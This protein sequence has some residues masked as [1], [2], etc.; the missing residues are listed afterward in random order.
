V[1]EE[2]VLVVGVRVLVEADREAL[3]ARQVS[4]RCKR[5]KYYQY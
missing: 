2:A 1:N 3:A 5:L 4:V